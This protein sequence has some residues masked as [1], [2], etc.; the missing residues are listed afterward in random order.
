MDTGLY[1]FHNLAFHTV[2]Q[3]RPRFA[4]FPGGSIDIQIRFL[5]IANDA[6]LRLELFN[7]QEFM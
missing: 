2:S 1:N 6:E 3:Q 4:P 5:Y 7:Q